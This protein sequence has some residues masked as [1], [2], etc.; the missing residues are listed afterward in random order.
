MPQQQPQQYQQITSPSQQLFQQQLQVQQQAVMAP[1]PPPPLQV[2]DVAPMAHIVTTP[3]ITP[4]ISEAPTP[5]SK[6]SRS[7]RPK[8][9]S[10]PSSRK[11][12][13]RKSSVVIKDDSDESMSEEFT[14]EGIKTK[15]GRKV[16]R[17]T[18][19]NPA[20][21]TPSRRRGPY[22]RNYDARICKLCQRGHSPQSNMIVFCDG[23][24]TPY[25]QLCHDPPIDDLVIQV[26]SAEWF[27][28][29]CAKSREQ[30]PLTMGLTGQSLTEEEKRMYLAS[31][32]M[33]SLV[34][35]LFFAEKQHPDLPIYDPQTKE[36]VAAQKAARSKDA[37]PGGTDEVAT[38]EG[39]GQGPNWE[40]M[41]VRAIAAQDIGKGVQP[42]WI[43][44]WISQN[45]PAL[46]GRDVRAEAQSTLQ[47]TLRKER[48]LREGHA[49]RLNPAWVGSSSLP[50]PQLE[51]GHLPPG[52]G[53]KLPLET[54]EEG[55]ASMLCDD[56]SI[57]FSHLWGDA[58][59]LSG[60]S[61]EDSLM[62]D[63]IMA[64]H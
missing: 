4:T 2:A 18:H 24:N 12:G 8:S 50:K 3:T 58:I 14:M 38:E 35:L 31:L 29:G 28:A 43:F 25:H 42:K 41:I 48:L 9:T 49:Y 16:H 36:I 52:G 33:S 22:R 51:P 34:E 55:A 6:I 62:M 60:A 30:R 17:P 13:R 15:S 1:P 23:C 59:Q 45:F 27:C 32:P 57:G 39:D 10:K 56:D 64:T 5:T 63:G 20:Q 54:E 19:F 37:T 11:P 46:E 47:A 53:I 61:V 7:A 21:K 40:E 44:E 26:E